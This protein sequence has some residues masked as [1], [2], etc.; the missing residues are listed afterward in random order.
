MMRTYRLIQSIVTLHNTPEAQAALD[1]VRE[2]AGAEC[3]TITP[4]DDP[5]GVMVATISV[6]EELDVP[7]AQAVEQAIYALTPHVV[8]AAQ[9]VTENDGAPGSF[10]IGAPSDIR[11]LRTSLSTQSIVEWALEVETP[12]LLDL[13]ARLEQIVESRGEKVPGA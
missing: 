3:V 8:G 12:V 7:E 4:A 11:R 9:V 13:L 6:A 5:A 10:F 1:V 2:R